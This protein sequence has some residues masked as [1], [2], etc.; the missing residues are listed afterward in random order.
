MNA[1]KRADGQRRIK[2]RGE[3]LSGNVSDVK[4]D[5]FVT[6]FEV[7][8]VVAAHFRHR[9]EFMGDGDPGQAKWMRGHHDVLNDASFLE[10]L[11][12][13]LFN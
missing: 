3:A 12:A 9:L 1:A 11:L 10:F 6:E 13:E 4:A 8:E 7:V 2:R 5:C